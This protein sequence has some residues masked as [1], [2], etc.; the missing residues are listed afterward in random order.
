MKEPWD[1]RP[2][3]LHPWHPVRVVVRLRSPPAATSFSLQHPSEG[4]VSFSE[5][6]IQY[7]GFLALVKLP[8]LHPTSVLLAPHAPPGWEVY[9]NGWSMGSS[10]LLLSP[11]WQPLESR[12]ILYDDTVT[13]KPPWVKD[14]IS[15]TTCLSRSTSVGKERSSLPHAS[16][17]R[18]SC[19]KQPNEVTEEG[20]RHQG[21]DKISLKSLSPLRNTDGTVLP[22]LSSWSVTQSKGS[23]RREVWLSGLSEQ[24]KGRLWLTWDVVSW[25]L[26]S[27]VSHTWI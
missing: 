16:S 21:M 3:S 5:W 7:R 6:A 8:A 12:R 24:T 19:G 11:L 9:G 17:M 27:L 14:S 18:A 10:C 15:Y 26:M 2:R 22:P 23:G 1:R 13:V 20:S 25:W 4:H